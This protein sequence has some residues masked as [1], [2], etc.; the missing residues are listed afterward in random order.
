MEDRNCKIENHL[1]KLPSFLS[2][3][4][5]KKQSNRSKYG[6]N[7]KPF[8]YFSNL[9]CGLSLRFLKVSCD[10]LDLTSTDMLREGTGLGGG[11]GGALLLVLLVVVVAAMFSQLASF[12][13]SPPPALSA[14]EP[15]GG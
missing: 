1:F 6:I 8:F 12:M 9:V 14:E 3:A 7:D 10:S 5:E 11:V 15:G 2:S 4:Y 13:S